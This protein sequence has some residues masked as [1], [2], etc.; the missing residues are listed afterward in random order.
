MVVQR[1]RR[2]CIV[3]WIELLRL[4]SHRLGLFDAR[5]DVVDSEKHHRGFDGGFVDLHPDCKG[6]PHA[7]LEE[8]HPQMSA[9]SSA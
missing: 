9:L 5:H 1:I 8:K 3:K 6:V 2:K 7:Q 4:P